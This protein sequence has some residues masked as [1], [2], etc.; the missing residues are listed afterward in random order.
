LFAILGVLE[1]WSQNIAWPTILNSLLDPTLFVH[2]VLVL[3]VASYLVD[4]G[5]DLALERPLDGRRRDIQI[6][7]TAQQSVLVETKSPQRLRT[8]SLLTAK[9]ASD[10]VSDAFRHTRTGPT[11]QLPASHPGLLAIG[12]F[13]QPEHNLELLENAARNLLTGPR[14]A[15][16]HIVG[17]LVVT[18]DV[19]A[20]NVDSIT[21][22][23]RRDARLMTIMRHRLVENPRYTG[24]LRVFR[25]TAAQRTREGEV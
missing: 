25:G 6:A 13:Y 17:V 15:L 1:R 19:A 5:N 2:T 9:E 11:G 18:L 22:E 20:T 23:I 21:G 14:L 10:V 16:E 12:G 3:V 7:A 4:A 24:S 8:G